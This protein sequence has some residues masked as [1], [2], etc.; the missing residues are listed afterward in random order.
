MRVRGISFG[1]N[2]P[3]A[4]TLIE[5]PFG[6]FRVVRKCKSY[7]FTLIELLVVV[8]IIAILA[9]M[10]LPALSAA[11]EKA[12]LASCSN[13][14]NQFGKGFVSYTSDYA[15]YLPSNIVWPNGIRNFWCTPGSEVDNG[16]S[17]AT[18]QGYHYTTFGYAASWPLPIYGKG[19]MALG[20][21]YTGKPGDTGTGKPGLLM[22]GHEL[23]MFRC[24]GY[25][26]KS[27]YAASEQNFNAGQLNMGPHGMGFLLS[28]GYIPDATSFY[29][30]SS[31]N[32]PSDGW[33]VNYPDGG[34][35][36][37][38]RLRDWKSAGGFDSKTF[39]YGNWNGNIWSSG[40]VQMI[41]SHYAYRNVPLTLMRGW[42]VYQN[43]TRRLTGT[44]PAVRV[45]LG[46]PFFRT[47]RELRGRALVCDTFSKGQSQDVYAN[48]PAV[49]GSPIEQSRLMVGYA[50][51]GHKIGYNVLY[52]D[53]HVEFYGD[54]DLK[55][56]YHTQGYTVARLNV[57]TLACN[58]F[59]GNNVD[60]FNRANMEHT[61]VQHS[62]VAVWHDFD[63]HGGIDLP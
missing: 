25:A 31:K 13:N 17:C 12:R 9:A 26:S 44:R 34:W 14:L 27:G 33:Y 4:F 3:A 32:M 58:Y 8:A 22:N 47:F 28:T 11:R 36:S 19:W 38:Y 62:S 42:H 61:Y 5:L 60:P 10:L 54:P 23:A 55:I 35:K 57:Y 46:Q 6:A 39:L 18:P 16:R 63:V 24:I 2:W 40:P 53:G 30:P 29:C 7:A 20:C 51:K 1:A 41:F 48:R 49:S 59:Y 15:G 37:K 43:N 52:G 56:T 50:Q 45:R 21:R